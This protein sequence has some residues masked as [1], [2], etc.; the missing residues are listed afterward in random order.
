MK[1]NKDILSG[2]VKKE[3]TGK[4]NFPVRKNEIVLVTP[5]DFENFFNKL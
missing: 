4:N 5:Q 3:D 2:N 1:W